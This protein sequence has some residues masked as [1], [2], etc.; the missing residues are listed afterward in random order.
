VRGSGF[1]DAPHVYLQA[2][3]SPQG[4]A[5]AFSKD[6]TEDP[7]TLVGGASTGLSGWLTA[8]VILLAIL[9]AVLF[10]MR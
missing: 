7:A 5:T 6:V 1:S 8:P 4:P 2:L 10:L 9:L 3:T